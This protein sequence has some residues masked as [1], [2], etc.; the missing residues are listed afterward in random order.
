MC[1]CVQFWWVVQLHRA[2]RAIGLKLGWDTGGINYK[3]RSIHNLQYYICKPDIDVNKP[4]TDFKTKI[5]ALQKIFNRKPN[6]IKGSQNIKNLAKEF[7]N[8]RI[9]SKKKGEG[10]IRIKVHKLI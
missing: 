4:P 7:Y 6:K 1:G 2:S 3:L 8:E 10:Y 5:D 9:E